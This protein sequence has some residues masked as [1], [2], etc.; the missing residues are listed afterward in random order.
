MT[1]KTPSRPKKAELENP[2]MV[3]A[4]KEETA[5]DVFIEHQKKALVE[6]RK[7]LVA[8]IPKNVQDH[9]KAAYKEALEGYRSFVNSV[10]DEVVETIEKVKFEPEKPEK[11]E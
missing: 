7:A 2:E 6:T 10:V 8:L 3:E 5:F 1:T 11:K 9:G 4:V